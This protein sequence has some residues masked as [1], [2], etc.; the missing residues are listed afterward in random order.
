[1]RSPGKSHRT[2]PS[3]RGRIDHETAPGAIDEQAAQPE[4]ADGPLGLACRTLAVVGIDRGQS[5]DSP[6][7]AGDQCREIVVQADDGFVRH[8]ALGIGD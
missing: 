1:M 8:A 2:P 4:L 3:G 6:G 5:M 7:M